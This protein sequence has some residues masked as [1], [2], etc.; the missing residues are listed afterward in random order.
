MTPD[1]GPGEPVCALCG[2][3]VEEHDGPFGCLFEVEP[4]VFCGAPCHDLPTKWVAA[5][6]PGRADGE[7]A[8]AAGLPA[9]DGGGAE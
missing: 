9:E 2:H 5:A 3:A 1:G 6:R 4:G 8:T 7:A